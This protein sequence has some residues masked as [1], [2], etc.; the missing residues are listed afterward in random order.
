MFRRRQKP[1]PPSFEQ[2]LEALR[3]QG[4]SVETSG[5]ASS[6][7]RISKYGCAAVVQRASASGARLVESPGPLIDGEIARLV[8][9]GY[10]KFFLTR[11]RGDEPALAEQLKT[12][13]EFEAELRHYL[14]L[15]ALYNV[16]LGTVSQRYR[17]D[18]L[19]GR[20]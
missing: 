7:V 6:P 3:Q 8:D 19:E 16:S 4:F 2:Q 20:E 15:P 13:H 14:N 5:G 10:Q 12:L 17:Y 9:K 11:A 18:R 1:R